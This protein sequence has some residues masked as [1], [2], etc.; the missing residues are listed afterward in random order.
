MKKLNKNH[1]ADN[2]SIKV[3]KNKLEQAKKRKDKNKNKNDNTFTKSDNIKNT[4]VIP[5]SK[6]AYNP[7][8]YTNTNGFLQIEKINSFKIS[9]KLTTSNFNKTITK[10]RLIKPSSSVP[11]YNKIKCPIVFNKMSGRERKILITSRYKEVNYTPKYDITRP[12]VPST[13]FK[14]SF[15]CSKF[16][17]FITGKLIR[18]YCFTPDK[19]FII[20]INKNLENKNIHNAKNKKNKDHNIIN[21]N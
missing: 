17:K 3:Y 19:Y 11:D 6:T 14:H 9:K 5:L 16:K 10:R 12:H 8:K 2:L 7:N 21:Y 1:S 13:T 18:S 15:D 4:K 20:E